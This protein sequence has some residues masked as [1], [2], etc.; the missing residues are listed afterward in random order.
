MGLDPETLR[1]SPPAH[2]VLAP[3]RSHQDRPAVRARPG[4]RH[5]GGG[6][7]RPRQPLRRRGVLR[8]GPRQRGSSP[9]IG[10]EVYVA[11]GSRFDKER[12]ERDA[13]GFDAINHLLLLAM[14]ETG[15]RNLMYL[16]SKGYLE[17]FYY[18][19]RI[20]LDLLRERSEGL[21]ATSGCLSSMVCRSILAGQ[22]D[23][24]WRQVEEFSEIFRDRYY[25]ELQRHGIPAQ[26]TGERRAAQDVL[27]HAPAAGRHQ[28]RP[29]P[30]AGGCP[31]PPRGAAV[32]R[33]RLQPGRPGPL[34]LRRAGLPREARATRWRRSSTTTRR[35]CGR[36][37]R[38][39]SAASS[40]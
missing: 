4:P 13:S 21:I 38:S 31:P 7:D 29:L 1:P 40:R 20:D 24:A 30:G 19:P 11:A 35:R 14:N 28:R 22:L 33:D 6:H 17:G 37:S 9:I 12:R 23:S 8:E 16:V 5:A 39:P 3:R 32:H 10:C 36:P 18:K 26:D 25:L 34:P 2:P 27:G 15:Y